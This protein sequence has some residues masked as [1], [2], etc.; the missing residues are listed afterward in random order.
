MIIT[1]EWNID[2]CNLSPCARALAV[3]FLSFFFGQFNLMYEMFNILLIVGLRLRH[4]FGVGVGLMRKRCLAFTDRLV[5][6]GGSWKFPSYRWL[7]ILFL[8]EWKK[9][10]KRRDRRS[11]SYRIDIICMMIFHVCQSN[12]CFIRSHPYWIIRYMQ[13]DKTHNIEPNHITCIEYSRQFQIHC[14][15]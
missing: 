12:H 14:Y 2:T 4:F 1:D 6:S 7:L 15:I 8:F 5:V 9:K 11:P 13:R 3:F 10:N